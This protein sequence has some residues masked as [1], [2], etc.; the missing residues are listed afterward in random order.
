MGVVAAL[1]ATIVAALLLIS[2]S[3]YLETN[4]YNNQASAG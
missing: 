4:K 2:P 3:S 1:V